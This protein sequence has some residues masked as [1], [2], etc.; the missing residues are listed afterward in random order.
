MI[1]DFFGSVQTVEL[2]PKAYVLPPKIK[3]V[4]EKNQE[5]EKEDSMI[6]H[7][8]KFKP[9]DNSNNNHNQLN[10]KSAIFQNIAFPNQFWSSSIVF[11]VLIWVMN[12]WHQFNNKI[13]NE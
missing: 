2:T 4:K 5:D 13:K 12:W 11:I 7:M 10:P 6:N 8:L 1:T 9:Y 3:T